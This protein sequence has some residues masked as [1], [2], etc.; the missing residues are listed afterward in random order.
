MYKRVLLK[1]SGEALG[2][3]KGLYDPDFL[4][5]LAEEIKEITNQGTGVAIVVGGG[6]LIRGRIL[7]ELGFDRVSADYM[8]MM[9]T[10]MNAI[11][12]ENVLKDH[13]VKAKALS[14]IDVETCEKYNAL[15]S[16]EYLDKG[17]VVIFGGGVSQ[18]YF[19]TDSTAVLRALENK[20]DVIFLAKNGT[21]GVYDSDPSLNKDAKK[22]TEIT[23]EELLERDLKVIDASAAAM[24][25]EYGLDAFVFNMN[26]KGNIKKA[27]NDT[28]IG[29][30][31]KAK[32][33]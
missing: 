29:T 14:A 25:R 2:N 28:T 9:G 3:G 1:L 6:N 27:I 22:F 21:D 26:G 15:N 33:K 12:L 24:A 5:E 13:N 23:Y 32:E 7:E 30:I 8:G 19:S 20:C 18:P 16:R 10:V 11:A 4:D 31:I 17:Y